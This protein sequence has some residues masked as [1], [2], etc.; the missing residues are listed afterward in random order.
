MAFVLGYEDWAVVAFAMVLIVLFIAHSLGLDC[1]GIKR[2]ASETWAPF[3][4]DKWDSHDLSDYDGH[5]K[6]RPILLSATG[7]VFDVSTSESYDWGKSYNCLAGRDGSKALAMMSLKEEDCISDTSDLDETQLQVLYDWVSYFINKRKYPMVGVI[8]R[9]HPNGRP[10]TMPKSKFD[11]G[12]SPF[13]DDEEE[14]KAMERVEVIDDGDGTTFR[15]SDND[16]TRIRQR[17]QQSKRTED[18]D[19]SFEID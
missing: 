16:N 2:R 14:E 17:S 15:A 3:D 10:K 8:P 5:E 7:L 13:D 11:K 4:P 1:L 18:A 6:T 12:G 19:A 9:I